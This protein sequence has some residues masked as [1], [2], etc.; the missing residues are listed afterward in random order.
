MDWLIK[1]HLTFVACN[2]KDWPGAKNYV[3]LLRNNADT[4]TAI[5]S[6]TCTQLTTYLDGVIY[7]GEGDL[8]GAL[9]AFQSD[10]LALPEDVNNRSPD[11]STDLRVLAAM[12]SILIMRDESHPQNFLCDPLISALEPLCE[13]SSNQNIHA[14]LNLIKSTASSM[15]SILKRKQ[16]L[17]NAIQYGKET[18]NNQILCICLTLM[19]EAFF[20]DSVGSQAEKSVMSASNMAQRWGDPMWIC[21]TSSLCSATFER[22]GKFQEA[23]NSMRLAMSLSEKLP[24]PL[25]QPTTNFPGNEILFLSSR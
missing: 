8:D 6:D 12:N 14:A 21:I 20:K 15:H 4:V 2:R 7:Q 24:E 18:N 1:L 17:S 25:K 5:S 9:A 10:I 16:Y 23:A 22:Q 11:I 3:Q 19:S 13:K